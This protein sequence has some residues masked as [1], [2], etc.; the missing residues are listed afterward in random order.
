METNKLTDSPSFGCL[1]AFELIGRLGGIRKAALALGFSARE[2]VEFE[3]DVLFPIA[4]FDPT[5][6]ERY[7]TVSS[8]LRE[9]SIATV[10]ILRAYRDRS[11]S[12]EAAR[13]ALETSA[14]IASPAALLE[15]ADDKGSYVLG[16]SIAPTLR[17][18][19]IETVTRTS[20][21]DPWNVLAR[22]ILHDDMRTIGAAPF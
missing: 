7:G 4:G 8:L 5:L 17:R 12:A 6:A 21:E 3:R 22:V 14:L 2:R 15:F 18:R 13:S 11:L 19:H 20:H 9:L 1:R 16:Y 10:P